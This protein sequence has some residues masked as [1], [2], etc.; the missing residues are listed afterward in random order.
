MTIRITSSQ[1]SP[2]VTFQ[3]EADH[4][5]TDIAGQRWLIRYVLRMAKGSG[6][7]FLNS[8]VQAGRGGGGE[9]GRV[10]QRPFLPV[11]TTSWARQFDVW[12]SAN[13]QGY[14]SG[15]STTYPL[16]QHL[17]YGSISSVSHGSMPLPRIAQPPSAPGTPNASQ[18]SAT[19]ASLTWAAPGSD[20][21][22]GVIGYTVQ[23]ALD[24]AFTSEVVT[25]NV[26]N[27]SHV[28]G[29]LTPGKTYRF[30]VAARNAAGTGV[31]SPV[32][33]LPLFRAPDAPTGV[34]LAQTGD[35]R[36]R[37]RFDPPAYDGGSPLT[38]F[39]VQFANNA[40]F[41]SPLNS[42]INNGATDETTVTVAGPGPWH[43]RVAARNA[44]GLG[45][46]ST[47]ASLTVTGD[48][49]DL[50]GWQVFTSNGGVVP[51]TGEGIRRTSDGLAL[52]FVASP[53]G[54]GYF[55]ADVVGERELPLV[56]GKTYRFELEARVGA[57]VAHDTEFIISGPGVD[58]F[59]M[60]SP[61][62]SRLAVTFVADAAEPGVNFWTWAESDEAVAGDWIMNIQLR[63]IRVIEI[64]EPAPY[65]LG[66]TVYEGPLARHFDYA[67][68][69]VGAAW[70]V[71]RT[72]RVTFR[73]WNDKPGLKA[74]FTDDPTV[75]DLLSYVDISASYDT[76]NTV[77][78]L[79]VQNHGRDPETGDADDALFVGDNTAA[80]S[81]WGRR[82]ATIDM[83]L[84]DPAVWMPQRIAEILSGT[85][86][87]EQVITRV[88]W[89]AQDR[90]G[91][92]STLDVQDRISV[93][94]QGQ[95]QLSRIVGIRHDITPTRWL[96]TLELAKENP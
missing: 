51:T 49:G 34:L 17:V 40:G 82:E 36:V 95:T 14:W 55:Y 91:L 53:E 22:A 84:A 24:D 13:A 9:F 32:A 57:P 80:I 77:T 26:S 71:D 78:A 56:P 8:G 38:G 10:E 74:H 90:P 31:W 85:S 59:A 39:R 2:F 50:D 18:A 16:E 1:V 47:P 27:A 52:E 60:L 6:S 62:W 75:P 54:T 21:G 67:C 15:T 83:T 61:E 72:N 73:E 48:V 87:P 66:N 35:R 28:F 25:A 29:N 79:A 19:S 93:A 33:T 46:W 23:R 76:R 81:E 64:R 4:V 63:K 12:V 42:D 89:N 70:W 92:A 94:F 30:R 69:T 86:T 44:A 58:D 11:G 65:R 45:S 88:T 3:L 7:N 37:V 20:N 43:Y 68:N 5:D 41:V 96:M